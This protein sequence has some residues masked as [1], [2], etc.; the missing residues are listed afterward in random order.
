M[1]RSNFLHYHIRAV[2]RWLL[3]L[4]LL[5]GVTMPVSQAQETTSATA[6]PGSD[7]QQPAGDWAK[8]SGAWRYA[9][10]VYG[11]NYLTI[12]VT[13]QGKVAGSIKGGNH[14]VK[15]FEGSELNC[16]TV[17]TGKFTDP[18]FLL[19]ATGTVDMQA[20]FWQGNKHFQH[21]KKQVKAWIALCRNQKTGVPY[22]GVKWDVGQWAQYDRY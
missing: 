19:I 10:R 13:S 11:W 5:A 17:K 1:K 4:G 21:P 14:N 6:S 9:S 12:S 20:G 8:Y 15:W 18:N 7:K 16:P 2:V 22:V 3:L